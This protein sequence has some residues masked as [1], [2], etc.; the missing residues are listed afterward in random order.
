MHR[1]RIGCDIFRI[2]MIR[3][4]ERQMKRVIEGVADERY[5]ALGRV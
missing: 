2:Q 1:G 5:I 3:L 4:R